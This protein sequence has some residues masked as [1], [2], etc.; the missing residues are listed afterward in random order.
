M[1]GANGIVKESISVLS[2]CA[3]CHFVFTISPSRHQITGG[4]QFETNQDK[5]TKTNEPRHMK[6]Y[7][8]VPK[9]H[10]VGNW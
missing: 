5:R 4:N 3:C 6:T 9:G 10:D 8:N 7:Q 2:S 1:T